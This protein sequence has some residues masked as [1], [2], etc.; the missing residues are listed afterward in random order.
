[1]LI[2]LEVNL[3]GHRR[4]FGDV[5]DEPLFE[6][7]RRRR[8]R[9]VAECVHA[10]DRCRVFEN[11]HRLGV[12]PVDDR[13]GQP[14]RRHQALPGADVETRHAA[15]GYGRRRRQGEIFLGARHRERAQFAVADELHH[16]RRRIHHEIEPAADQLHDGGRAAAIGHVQHLDL[17]LDGEQLDGKMR[18]GADAGRA[19][20]QGIW[21]FARGRD[22][23]GDALDAAVD[24]CRQNIGI[25]GRQRNHGEVVDGT[26]RQIGKRRRRAGVAGGD[27]AERVTVGRRARD[28]R[29][30][31]R[32]RRAGPRLDDHRLA[33]R[34]RQAVGNE[35]GNDV[36]RPARREAM[37]DGDGA[38]RPL[39][40]GARLAGQRKS[41]E[42]ADHGA[43]GELFG[44]RAVSSGS[45]D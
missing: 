22:Q 19:V 35:A 13:L 23:L 28:L 17:G 32:A 37:D 2:F 42:P 3:L 16:G 14:G 18:P 45:P 12:E 27:D 9:L 5:V 6:F 7:G 33:E 34:A 41:G 26:V 4:P 44:H 21:P 29:R 31:R 15:F 24:V 25:F 43:A 11:T 20:E 39:R 30:R 1:M 40:L 36:G 38:R 10:L 8:R